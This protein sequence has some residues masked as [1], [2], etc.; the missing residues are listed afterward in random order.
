MS[1]SQER[2]GE[3]ALARRAAI[4]LRL[5]TRILRFGH[6]SSP[7]RNRSALIYLLRCSMMQASDCRW[8]VQALQ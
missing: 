4:D 3:P 1:R 2:C 8:N 6:H 5:T 7:Q